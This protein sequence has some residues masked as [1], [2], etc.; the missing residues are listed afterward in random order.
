MAHWHGYFQ[1]Q[2]KS[3]KPDFTVDSDS[4]VTFVKVAPV[5]VRMPSL[6]HI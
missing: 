4:T 6:I 3:I 5:R 1:V 2:L